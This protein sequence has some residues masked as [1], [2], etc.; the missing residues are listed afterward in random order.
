[1]LFRYHHLSIAIVEETSYDRRSK[2]KTGA[3]VYVRSRL[4]VQNSLFFCSQIVTE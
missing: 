4:T 3:A 2:V 1:M